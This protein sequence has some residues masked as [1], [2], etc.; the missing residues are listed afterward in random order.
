MT[1][2]KKKVNQNNTKER[3]RKIP[4]KITPDYLHNSGLY[5]LQRYAASTNHFKD[6][7]ARKAKRSCMYHLDQDFSKCLKLIDELA[8]KFA[9][10]GLLDDESYAYGLASSYRRQGLS[11][12]MIVQK[13]KI[14]GLDDNQIQT[15]LQKV[16]CT[17]NISSIADPEL[18]AALAFAR[19]KRLG[20]FY[21]GDELKRPEH[22]KALG[23]FARA[24]FSYDIA[25]KILAIESERDL[26]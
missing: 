13:M 18:R 15:A 24:G 21:Q 2:V 5:Y 17:S 1:R 7:M 16:D 12:R 23:R 19:K 11:F 8:D 6:V 9:Q 3:K 20:I 14:K 22:Q 4:K 25:N 10:V 26:E